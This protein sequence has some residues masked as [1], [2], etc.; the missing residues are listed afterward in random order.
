[1][2]QCGSTGSLREFFWRC[3]RKGHT[4]TSKTLLHRFALCFTLTLGMTSVALAQSTNSNTQA[5]G[6]E[7]VRGS[8]RGTVLDPSGALIPEAQVTISNANGFSRTIQSG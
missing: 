7:S 2:T 6:G 5:A 3:S 4:M 1:M 8:I